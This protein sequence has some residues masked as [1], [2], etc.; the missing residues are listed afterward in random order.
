MKRKTREVIETLIGLAIY[1][2]AAWIIAPKVVE[3]LEKGDYLLGAIV[4]VIAFICLGRSVNYLNR[5]IFTKAK[6]SH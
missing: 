2:P 3:A 6:N 1:I 5:L 4:P